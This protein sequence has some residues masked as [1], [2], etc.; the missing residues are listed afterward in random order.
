MV[1]HNVPEIE[2]LIGAYA[3]D[4]VDPDERAAVEQHLA[5]CARCR[6]E[7][8]EHR[9]VAALLAYE[10]NP[11]PSVVWDRIV[12]SLEEPPPALRLTV[13]SPMDVVSIEERRRAKF[14][15]RV[16]AAIAAVAA[17]AALVL[18]IVVVSREDPAPFEVD[19]AQ[20]AGEALADPASSKTTLRPADGGAGPEVTAV[21]TPEG[22]G[23]IIGPD[24]PAL[25]TDR[26]YQLWGITG[27]QAISLGVLGT[28]PDVAAFRVDDTSNFAA[29]AITDEV[30]GGV[31]SSQNDPLV[32]GET[33]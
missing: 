12:R 27:D 23:F 19:L 8:A 15:R 3:L 20:V 13:E 17:V 16:Y 6:A 29:F 9:E 11:A 28:D 5:V 4:A 26:T 24:L 25:G 32:V 7:L 1:E 33:A 2:E 18:G 21:V 22:D 30:S 31:I 14:Q 10:G